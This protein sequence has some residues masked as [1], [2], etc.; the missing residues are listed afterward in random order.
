MLLAETIY[1]M[2]LVYTGLMEAAGAAS[3]V[4]ELID[5][6]PTI[7]NDGALEPSSVQ[8]RVEFRDVTFSYPSRPETT[9]LK[10]VTFSLDP[11]EV[12]ALVGP[13]G[14]GKSSCISL[15]E[16]FYEPS[17]GQILLDGTPISKFSHK[18]FHKMISLVG[19]EPVLY[20]RS[21]SENIAYGLEENEYDFDEI[22]NSAR[23]ANAHDF[24]S[25]L[26]GGYKTDVG[27][28]GAQLS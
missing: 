2:G 11:G 5:R 17:S 26:N 24:I 10:G 20:A 15:L 25:G 22:V 3:K 12:V 13:S 21:I 27:E 28:K 4:F 8:G 9:V 14:G 7:K 6:K 1:A 23:L 16:H 19:Q 18:Y